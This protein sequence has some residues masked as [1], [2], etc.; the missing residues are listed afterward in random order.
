MYGEGVFVGYRHYD[1]RE[2][3]RSS[4]SASGFPTPASPTP[5]SALRPC[6]STSQ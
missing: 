3:A 5:A 1:A 6:S 2:I 4:R